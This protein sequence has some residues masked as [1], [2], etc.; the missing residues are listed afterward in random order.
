M[1]GKRNVPRAPAASASTPPPKSTWFWWAREPDG[2][3]RALEEMLALKRDEQAALAAVIQRI[4]QG[5]TRSGDVKRLAK[6]ILEARVRLNGVFVRVAY[7]R[8]G[9]H[10]VGLTVFKKQKNQTES[11]DLRRAEDRLRDW[12]ASRGETPSP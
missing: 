8:W 4:Q 6:D 12:R 11:Q 9:P 10:Y 5:E 2:R 1:A 7:S 3:S